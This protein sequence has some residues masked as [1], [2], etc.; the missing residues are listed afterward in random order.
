MF[1]LYITLSLHA[2]FC[3]F[4]Q[5][6]HSIIHISMKPYVH[7]KR[8]MHAYDVMFHETPDDE[9]DNLTGVG[10]ESTGEPHLSSGGVHF[11]A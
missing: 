7:M 8:Y 5:H 2:V 11:Q 9:M 3:A 1:R 4:T 6:V 10:V